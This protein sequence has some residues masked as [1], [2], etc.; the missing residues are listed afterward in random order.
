M[1][2]FNEFAI[3]LFEG[4]GA[5]RVRKMFGGA[6]LY[7]N[8]VMFALIDEETIYLKTDEALAAALI[9]EGS[10]PWIYAKNPSATHTYYRLPL[11][12]LDN[13]E[14]AARW[15]SRAYAVAAALKKSKKPIAT[16]R[17]VKR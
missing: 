5:V 15:G 14:E 4:M 3:E 12:A 7:L 17:A 2:G 9:A 13:A 11:D 10:A 16:K 1:S 6:G 8:D